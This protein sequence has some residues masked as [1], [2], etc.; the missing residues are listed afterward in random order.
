MG[1]SRI[2][3]AVLVLKHEYDRT[4]KFTIVFTTD[5][6]KSVDERVYTQLKGLLG[7][8]LDLVVYNSRL[9]LESQVRKDDFVVIDEADQILLDY[10]ESLPNHSRVL[11]LSATPFA[12]QKVFEKEFL[13]S[14]KFKCID[15]KISGT[16][17]WK[18]AT[19]R[20]S[21]K[22][23]LRKSDGYAKLIFDADSCLPPS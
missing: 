13:E 4:N 15:S 11:A 10:Q 8:D 19:E 21:L 9:L 18:T 1:K 6:L 2:I 7:L 20:A 5:L 3:A 14:S 22:D 17:N 16:I 12:E 23:F